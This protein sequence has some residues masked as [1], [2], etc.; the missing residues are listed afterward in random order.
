MPFGT[1]TSLPPQPTISTPILG[2]CLKP[3]NSMSKTSVSPANIGLE[4]MT[5][6]P[7]SLMSITVAFAPLLNLTCMPSRK[8]LGTEAAGTVTTQSSLRC[9]YASSGVSVTVIF[10]PTA[11]PRT[12]RSKPG[13]TSPAPTL[14]PKGSPPSSV[15]SNTVPSCKRPRYRTR[16]SSPSFATRTSAASAMRAKPRRGP[17]DRC[18][19]TRLAAPTAAAAATMRRQYCGGRAVDDAPPDAARETR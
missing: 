11:R 9:P 1:C 10:L 17:L 5:A 3:T 16:T 7:S 18:E 6:E 13:T 8:P 14:K 2:S 12:A 15:A 19:E 4:S